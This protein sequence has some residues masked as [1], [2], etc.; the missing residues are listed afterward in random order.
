[1]RITG[2][3]EAI[4]TIP[5]APRDVARVDS[6]R[7][8]ECRHPVGQSAGRGEGNC[9]DDHPGQGRAGTGPRC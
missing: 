2:T 5:R 1:M 3:L 6:P 8:W 7:G 4:M 9:D